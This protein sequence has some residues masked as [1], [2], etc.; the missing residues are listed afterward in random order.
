MLILLMTRPDGTE[1]K[2]PLETLP[3]IA[4][5]VKR[6]AIRIKEASV[7]REHARFFMSGKTLVVADLNSINGTFVNEKRVTRSE[8]VPGDTI[9]LGR[10]TFRLEEEAPEPDDSGSVLDAVDWDAEFET[11]TS[12]EIA[13]REKPEEPAQPFPGTAAG[14]PSRSTGKPVPPTRLKKTSPAADRAGGEK[15]PGQL[16]VKDRILQ[17]HKIPSN[18]K[19][20]LLHADLSQHHPLYRLMLILVIL[21]LCVGLFFLARW[22]TGSFMPE[23]RED[24]SVIETPEGG[25]GF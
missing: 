6:A 9:R 22:L 3:V 4:G 2:F 16:D 11:G 17:Y 8:V 13:P 5:R 18:R 20:S 23:S 19:G 24:E 12:P 15:G 14:T 1:E 7:S 25:D 10:I 21:L